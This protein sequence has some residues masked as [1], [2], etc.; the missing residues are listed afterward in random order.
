LTKFAVLTLMMSIVAS[1]LTL[2]A[3]D[4][5]SGYYPVAD[6]VG[7]DQP[8]PFSFINNNICGICKVDGC[9]TCT[10]SQGPKCEICKKGFYLLD[11]TC[12]ICSMDGCSECNNNNKCT[13]C[14]DG[15]TLRDGR[16]LPD[17]TNQKVC[18]KCPTDDGCL[19]CGDNVCKSCKAGYFLS[20]DGKCYKCNAF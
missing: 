12:P 19:E 20:E 5:G 15:W 3:E 1:T 10:A 18:L 11:N 6:K 16:E 7:N 17:G 8:N 14:N 4:C 13:K 2:W 9:D